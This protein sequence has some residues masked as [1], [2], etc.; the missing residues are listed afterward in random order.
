[1]G[2]EILKNC[3]FIRSFPFFRFLLVGDLFLQ[4]K[5]RSR[6]PGNALLEVPKRNPFCEICKVKHSQDVLQF[7]CGN[8]F[9]FVGTRE[10]MI[11]S[12]L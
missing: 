11:C 2:V 6:N 1:M 12:S 10:A 5:L 8:V 3:R 7:I 9:S 4:A